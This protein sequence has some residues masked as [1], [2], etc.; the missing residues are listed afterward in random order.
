MDPYLSEIP[1]TPKEFGQEEIEGVIEQIIY[2]HAG[3]GF[4]VARLRRKDTNH[5]ITIV[6]KSLP[7]S[8]GTT[9][10]VSGYWINHPRFG[11]QF[12]TQKMEL[13]QPSSTEAV[14]QFLASGAIP[15][16]G[17]KYAERIIKTFGSDVLH[18]LNH[19]P[20]RLT[21]VPRLGKK[22]AE[23]IYQ[24]WKEK[25]EFL[26]VLLCLQEYHI[27]IGL[28]T[29]LY[30]YYGNQVLTFLRE[31]PFQIASEVQG[32]GFRTADRIAKQLGIAPDHP[33]RI[34][35]GIRYTL[36]E[37]E[38]DGHVFL[39]E[40][41][42]VKSASELLQLEESQIINVLHDMQASNK[43]YIEEQSVYLPFH[44]FVEEECV[45]HLKRIFNTP[46]GLPKHL[47][48]SEFLSS[49]H[50]GLPMLNEEQQEA[51]RQIFKSKITIITGGPGTGKTTLIKSL[52][53]F[54]KDYPV[55]IVLTA[56]TG[57]A[58]RQMEAITG[59]PACTIHRLLEFN[60]KDGE[61]NRNGKNP[62]FC[63]LLIVDESSMVDHVLFLHLL[64]AV[65]STTHIVFVGDVDQLPSVGPGNVLFDLIA[66]EV[67]NVIRLKTIFRQ[68]A[69]SGI[70][71]NAHRVNQ[72]KFPE[73]NQTDFFFIRRG[74]SPDALQT[75][76]HIV[77]E[78]IPKKF[79][80]DPIRDIQVL[81]PLRRGDAGVHHLN[82]RLQEAL[83]PKGKPIPHS[84][85]R[86]GD[87][88]MQIKNNYE[89]EVF[90]GDI[91]IITDANPEQGY[92]TIVFE[93]SH[94]VIYTFEQLDQ[95][96]LA[97]SATVHKAQGSEYPVV[98]LL[99]LAQHYLLLQRNV[100]Y[101]AITRAK[102]L[103]T[104][105]GSPNAIQKALHSTHSVRRNTR[106]TERIKTSF[107]YD[108]IE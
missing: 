40:D 46:S 50:S 92:I 62:I 108:Y 22:R 14:A 28:A 41:E 59:H 104:I 61:P 87:K 69:Q 86:I 97:Y 37:A 47:P 84:S 64:R 95:I 55:Q 31:D 5:L 100:L 7:V 101:T 65:P 33:S 52:V 36:Q 48:L 91:G 39:R 23:K 1:F 98:V 54:L 53:Y 29:K 58:A 102:K 81:A 26:E 11:P 83:N 93:P 85:F 24:V 60:P 4:F 99:M 103:V 96:S 107:K 57:R 78:R 45:K 79:G 8:Q 10:C 82:Y 88:V 25:Q 70:I 20:E 35:A 77:Q 34:E 2:E 21:L 9:V 43:V 72:G 105:I 67:F 66:S 56:P 73:F 12:Q 75:L 49:Q 6:G 18:V 106:L 74:E 42:V 38:S 44:Y 76:L 68:S 71:L 90:N 89:K 3:S 27:P 16:I 30:K 51:I 15:G 94:P 17:T 19:E 32:I 63:N 13:V 80:Y